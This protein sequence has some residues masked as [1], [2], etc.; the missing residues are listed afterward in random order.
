MGELA[1]RRFPACPRTRDIQGVDRDAAQPSL[2]V[3]SPIESRMHMQRGFPH[4]LREFHCKQTSP[5]ERGCQRDDQG[6]IRI[7]DIGFGPRSVAPAARQLSELIPVGHLSVFRLASRG[8]PSSMRNPL[9]DRPIQCSPVGTGLTAGDDLQCGY[10]HGVIR[11]PRCV[12]CR[13]ATS[14]ISMTPLRQN[15]ISALP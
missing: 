11:K 5:C 3:R 2:K 9:F 15:P 13:Q 12:W 10:V 4:L 14:N 6:R 8:A 7:P 1:D